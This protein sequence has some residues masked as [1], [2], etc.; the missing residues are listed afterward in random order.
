MKKNRIYA[1][2]IFAAAIVFL[3]S[4][5]LIF[6]NLFHLTPNITDTKLQVLQFESIVD[7]EIYCADGQV[8]VIDEAAM[9]VFNRE[10]FEATVEPQDNIYVRI[11][12]RQ[13]DGAAGRYEVFALLSGQN[14]YLSMDDVVECYS[15]YNA[16][17]AL[18]LASGILVALGLTVFGFV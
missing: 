4:T 16:T 12:S 13:L 6:I 11:A 10:A 9:D 3:V 5:I 18:I 15:E 2:I 14:T 7:N 8:A 17:A 1:S